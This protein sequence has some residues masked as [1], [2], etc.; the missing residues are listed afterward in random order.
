MNPAGHAI[1]FW[2]VLWISDCKIDWHVVTTVILTH[3]VL[4]KVASYVIDRLSEVLRQ[5]PGLRIRMQRSYSLRSLALKFQGN[6]P[7]LTPQT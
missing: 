3:N 7:L 5:F 4:N 6:M 2:A 1:T